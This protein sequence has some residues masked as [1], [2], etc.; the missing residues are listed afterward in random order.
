MKCALICSFRTSRRVRRKENTVV[1]A[2]HFTAKIHKRSAGK[3]AVR[4]AAYRSGSKLHDRRAGKTENYSRK[5]DVI[6]TAILAPDD[7]PGWVYD[8]EEFWNRVEERENRKDAQV[9]QEFEINLPRELPDA[10]NWRLITDFVRAKLVS[11]GRICDIAFH[12]SLAGDGQAHPHVHI[13]MPM[14][15]LHDGAFSEKH[16]SVDW[17]NFFGKTDRISQLRAEWCEF[18]RARA[19]ELGFDLGPDWDYRSYQ[20]RGIDIE[21]EPKIGGAAQRIR[22]EE[23]RSERTDEVLAA[24]RRNGERL[25]AD[26]AIALQALTNRQST[27]TEQDLARWVHKHSADD[28][29][30]EIFAAAKAE[31]VLIGVDDRGRKRYSTKDMIALENR[32]LADAGIMARRKG[33]AV[34]S[35]RIL[36]RL[37]NST[38]SAEQ[39]DA[40]KNLLTGGDLCC[41]V[42]YAG[43]GKS[44]MLAEVRA[45]LERDGYRVRGAALSGIAAEKLEQGSGI[46]ARTLASWSYRWAEGQDRLSKKDVLVIDEAGM[47]GTR[48]LSEVIERAEK[49]GA[50]LILVGDPEQL[51]AIEAGAAFRGVAERTGAQ[52][53]REVRRQREP[54]Q[55]DA[56]VELATGETA[57]A[58]DR[59]RAADCVKESDTGEK[60]RAALIAAW[61]RSDA[62]ASRIILAHT[63]EDVRSLNS[64]ARQAAR[65]NGDLGGD[66]AVETSR[67][68][69]MFAE[70]DRILFLKNDRGLG[71]KNGTLATIEEIG[72]ERLVA[73]TDEGVTVAIELDAYRDIDHGYAVTVHK[74]QGMT[75]DHS[76]VLLTEGFDRHL[77]YV[78]MSRHRAQL[79]L[80]FGRDVFE[81]DGKLARVLGRERSKDLSADYIEELAIARGYD[82]EASARARQF[83]QSLEQTKVA[84]ATQFHPKSFR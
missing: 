40:A 7:A 70:G 20:E 75:V 13:L 83:D 60:A 69:R 21:A 19:A 74:A 9:A 62:G 65:M 3:S 34:K 56:T 50:K 31:A 32:L 44:T 16:A 36:R 73:R 67:G 29:F 10:E 42:G 64:E 51:Q 27:F 15:V 72:G 39:R 28:Q 46:E 43:A 30:A 68:R 33:H 81:S 47:V 82:L 66:I 2:F 78:S 4:S 35:A 63:N 37:D 71:V 22:R 12:T 59:Y 53:L 61:I 25:L 57:N 76:F 23:G 79:D 11:D 14:R 58:L 48:Q 77:A 8:R 84:A 24:S 80:F 41:L 54:W 1:G 26:P 38:L 49:A 52:E 6:E 18:S 5:K 45:L 17:R 55:C